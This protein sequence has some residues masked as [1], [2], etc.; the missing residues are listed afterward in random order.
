MHEVELVDWEKRL[1]LFFN[2]GFASH[3]QTRASGYTNSCF[4]TKIGDF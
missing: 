3:R 2:S 4:T 1:D